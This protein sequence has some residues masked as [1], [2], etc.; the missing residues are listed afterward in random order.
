VVHPIRN[1]TRQAADSCSGEGGERGDDGGVHRC[2][3]QQ[4]PEV[5]TTG[6]D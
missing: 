5:M 4:L 3:P 2:S 6:P 1:A